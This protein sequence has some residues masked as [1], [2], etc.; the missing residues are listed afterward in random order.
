MKKCGK[1]NTWLF[2]SLT[3]ALTNLTFFFVG[4]GD[5]GLVI[6]FAGLNGFPMG[7][8]GDLIYFPFHRGAAMHF[9]CG[10][11]MPFVRGGAV[12]V[13]VGS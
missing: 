9:V 7:A 4:K 8:S 10:A 5:I 1:R 13:C 3:M 11:A 2:W 12:P 6:L